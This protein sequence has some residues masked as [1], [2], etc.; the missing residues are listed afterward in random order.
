MKTSQ[1][2]SYGAFSQDEEMSSP[3]GSNYVIADYE[4]SDVAS[5]VANGLG[6]EA[7]VKGDRVYIKTN[8]EKESKDL[9]NLLKDKTGAK[10][11]KID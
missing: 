5:S 6:G 11:V 7:A 1:N 9:K 8:S 2:A 4:D 3:N 10:R